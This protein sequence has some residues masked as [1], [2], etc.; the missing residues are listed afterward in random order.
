[1][2]KKK[3]KKSVKVTYKH[4][5][6]NINYTEVMTLEELVNLE[7]NDTYIEVISVEEV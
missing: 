2:F 3:V 4:E 7:I 1:M 6:E 5:R